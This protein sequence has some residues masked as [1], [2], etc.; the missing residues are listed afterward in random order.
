MFYLQNA[1][2][3][4]LRGIVRKNRYGLLKDDRSGVVLFV[5]NVDGST[6]PVNAVF[7]NRFVHSPAVHSFSSE[8][9]QEGGMDVDDAV[10]E[11]PND[12]HGNLL[13]VTR[14]CN[15]VGIVVVKHFGQSA[16]VV[17]SGLKV[18]WMNHHRRKTAFFRTLDRAR[19]RS[20]CEEENNVQVKFISSD[21]I[22]Y[23]LEIAPA[24]GGEYGELEPRII[25]GLARAF[26]LIRG[27]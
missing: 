11:H 16:R 21:G 17:V 1:L 26:W 8:G 9:G 10:L 4:I 7:D 23:R 6:G 24:S 5:Y 3:Y 13:Q 25:H 12:F 22:Q 19:A 20:I 2:S 15:E 14:E 27:D 18:L